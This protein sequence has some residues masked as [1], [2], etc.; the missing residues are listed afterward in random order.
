MDKW[1][2]NETPQWPPG[3]VGK[4]TG[5]TA[6]AFWFF[7][8]ELVKATEKYEAVYR[9]MKA[10]LLGYVQD[11][12]I[13]RQRNTHLQVDAIFKPGEDGISFVLKGTFLD[14][15][16]GE[17]ERPAMW[18][19]LAAGSAIGHAAASIPISITCVAGPCVKIND[20]TFRFDMQKEAVGNPKNYVITFIATHP[21]D[22]VYKPALQQGQMVVPAKNTTGIAQHI[23][24]PAIAGCKQGAKTILLQAVSDAGLPVHYYIKEGPAQMNGN[25][26]K[27]SSIPLRAKFPVKVTVVA[28]QYGKTAAPAVQTAEPAERSFYISR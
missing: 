18:T 8:E 14:T 17:S 13:I 1:R 28:W 3:T 22:E 11:G 4:Y 23:V 9:N 10:Q 12:K 20:T 6:Q 21:G 7:D 24:F 25:R 27:L 2:F 15:V 19:G 5:D 16:P 26:L